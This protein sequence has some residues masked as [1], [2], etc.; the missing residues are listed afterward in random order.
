[1]KFDHTFKITFHEGDSFDVNYINIMCKT[2]PKEKFLIEI[3]N[4]KGIT[5]DMIKALDPNIAI[6]IAGGYDEYR[7]QKRKNVLFTNGESG[8]FYYIDAV[9]YSPKEVYLIL[10]EIEK[11][12]SDID[13]NWSSIQKI[14]Y[15]YN[16]LVT[17]II[18]DPR[19]EKKGSEEIRSLRGLITKKTVCGGYSLIFKEFMDR[20]GIECEY[21]EGHT[22]ENNEGSHAWNIVVI[23]GKKYPI[24]LTFDSKRYRLGQTNYFEW[25]C[26]SIK[27]FSKQ[28]MPN[29]YEKTQDYM[30]TLTPL[31][32]DVVKRIYNLIISA[33]TQDIKTAV[34]HGVRKDYSTFEVTRIENVEINGTTYYRYY[35]VDSDKKDEPLILYSENNISKFVETKLFDKKTP[36]GYEDCMTDCLFSKENIRDSLKKGSY[37][38]GNANK[39]SDG[40]EFEPVES[41]QEI[42]KPFEKSNLFTYQ[43]KR[44]VRSNGTSF[45]VQKI[46]RQAIDN[47]MLYKYDI[48]EMMTENGKKLLKRNVVYSEEDFLRDR[49][50]EIADVFLSRR[51]IDEKAKT[52]GGYIGYYDRHG[53]ILYKP[54]LA[55]SLSPSKKVD[56]K[57]IQ[58][59]KVKELNEFSLPTF[60]ELESLASKYEIFIDSDNPLED[61]PSKYRVRDINTK[62]PLKDVQLFKKAMFANIWLSAA[63]IK[64]SFND[65]RAGFGYAFNNQAKGYYTFLCKELLE[66]CR[67]NRVIDTYDLLTKAEK[68]KKYKY[69][70][71]ITANLFR[72]KFQTEFLN[73]L[74]LQSV[75]FQSKEKPKPLYSLEYAYSHIDSEEKAKTL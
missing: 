29:K 14:I 7:I 18:Y 63:G 28:H 69:D 23:D 56:I 45:L 3:Q 33:R 53:Q 57:D 62:Q 71:E 26:Q 8:E 17:S 13:E 58:E 61:D 34:Y 59:E 73:M 40:D 44:Y 47:V 6:R 1:M 2:H 51:R 19:F 5:S 25:L 68:R 27:K 70:E 22:K 67:R 60:D 52:S 16:K 10:R 48:F 74:F 9:T 64:R 31:D 49:R 54:E 24:D 50:K 46:Q 30:N 72:S 66:S 11:I 32:P 21:V 43:T 55:K 20:Q 42:K 41:W 37:F 36:E 75:G 38:I 39:S 4:T 65:P 12:E 15:V 35:Y